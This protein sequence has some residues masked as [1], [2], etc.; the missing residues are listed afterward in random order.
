MAHSP[1]VSVRISLRRLGQ[2]HFIAA[3]QRGS[4]STEAQMLLYMAMEAYI[5][6]HGVQKECDAYIA[7][8]LAQRAQRSDLLDGPWAEIWTS[9]LEEEAPHARQ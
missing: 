3:R 5:V 8:F 7:A 2:L 1:R 9:D 4:V 6:R